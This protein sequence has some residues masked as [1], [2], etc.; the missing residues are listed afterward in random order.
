MRNGKNPDCACSTRARAPSTAA[1][2]ASTVGWWLRAMPDGLVDG[3]VTRRP[4]DGRRR[5]GDGDG[6]AIATATTSGA[7][8]RAP[9]RA[10]INHP[11]AAAAVAP[12]VPGAARSRASAPRL[13]SARPALPSS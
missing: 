10:R 1:R 12:R 5:D 4:G 3:E 7:P 2:C 9:V 11:A 8:I 6:A 13:R